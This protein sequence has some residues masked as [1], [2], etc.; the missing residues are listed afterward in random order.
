MGLYDQGRK[1]VLEACLWLS[2]HGFFGSLRGTGG[3]VSVRTG[4]GRLMAVTP[5]SVNYREIAP[6]DICI[7]DFSGRMVEG[8]RTPSVESGLH[9]VVYRGRPDVN[10]VIHSHQ[11]YG[12]AFA[13]LNLPIPSLLDEVS[14]TL[15]ETIDVVPYALS[16]SAELAAN[17]AGKLGNSA[18]AYIMQNHGVL[19]LGKNI[20]RALL[21]AE[22]LEKVA[23]IYWLALATGRPVTTLPG[24]ISDMARSLREHEVNKARKKDEDKS[25]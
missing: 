22:L 15:G 1:E 4:D 9:A 19:A 7:V 2:D 10:A 3:N 5:S 20:D 24:E 16:G 14:F 21:A 12:S 11:I 23:H 25:A 8:S 13:V 17:V 6:E 18:N